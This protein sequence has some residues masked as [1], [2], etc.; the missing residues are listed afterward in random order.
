MKNTKLSSVLFVLCSGIFILTAMLA[1]LLLPHGGYSYYENRN[2]AVMPQAEGQEIMNGKYFSSVERYLSDNAAAR[3]TLLRL[4][5]KAELFVNVKLLDCPVVN[6]VVV[7]DDVLLP[8]NNYESVYEPYIEAQAEEMVSNLKEISD[9]TASYGG[10][11][12]Y[13][14]VP[15]QYVS[16]ADEYPWY[17]NSREEY[18]SAS[19]AAFTKALEGSDVEFIDMLDTLT[20]ESVRDIANSTV[21]SHYSIYGAYLTYLAVMEEINKTDNLK[22]LSEDEFTITPLPNHYVGSRSRK[23]FDLSNVND[24]IDILTPD[25]EVPFTRC[26]NGNKYFPV[27][28]SMPANEYEGV[29]YSLYMGGDIAETIIDTDRDELPSVLVYGDSFTNAFETIVYYSFNEMHSLDFRYYRAMTLGEY[30][31]AYKPD[32]VICIR[33][34][35]QLI[36]TDNN[37]CG[38]N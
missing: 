8:F 13:V 4:K 38:I 23:L 31:E 6:E 7:L 30:I 1:S 35:E 21:D 10:R 17:L 29:L 27:L 36:V 2:L 3:N 32:Y 28:Y 25:I 34:Y 33:D 15:C 14:A 5:T 24:T 11:Y 19:R 37:G 12:F 22:I 26:D 20:D 18:T 9:L 16:Y